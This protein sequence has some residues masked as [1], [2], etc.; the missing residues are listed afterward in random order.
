MRGNQ[1]PIVSVPPVRGR[2]ALPNQLTGGS[3]D[4]GVLTLPDVDG[5]TIR[6]T[7]V[8]GGAPADFVSE[9]FSVDGAT[10]WVAPSPGDVAVVDG[11]GAEQWSS[12]GPLTARVV[13]DV[14]AAIERNLTARL[15]AGPLTTETRVTAGSTGLG[16]V[17][18]STSGAVIRAGD[19]KSS[20]ELRGGAASVPLGPPPLDARAPRAATVDLGVTHHGIGLHPISDLLPVAIGGVGGPLV[21]ATPV[22]RLLPPDALAGFEVRCLAVV[23]WT[24]GTTDLTIGIVEVQG[25]TAIAPVGSRPGS[26]DGLQAGGPPYAPQVVWVDLPEALAIG[27]TGATGIGISVTATR[28]S[29]RWA[30]SPEPGRA[31]R[32]DDG[33]EGPSGPRRHG[34]RRVDGADHGRH[35]AGAP[36]CRVRGRAAVDHHRPVRHRQRLQPAPGVRP[37]SSSQPAIRAGSVSASGTDP[38]Q[39]RIPPRWGVHR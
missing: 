30:A 4:S 32:R 14:A 27:A 39:I 25:T 16:A 31:G 35:R 20:V 33:A 11:T 9:T 7:I 21:T 38:A 23:G 15:P 2:N 37:M 12:A 34:G 8:T 22:L 18:Q 10:L 28:G 19:P 36:A 1:A 24:V 26:I 13:V 17:H 5:P 6:I 29:F 3:F